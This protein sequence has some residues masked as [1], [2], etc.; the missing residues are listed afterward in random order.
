VSDE[1]DEPIE[2]AGV[3]SKRSVET[4]YWVFAGVGS[5][6]FIAIIGY[7]I[8]QCSRTNL[9]D[10]LGEIPVLGL[11]QPAEQ[12]F[13]MKPGTELLFAVSSSYSYSG[14][15]VVMLDVSLLRDGTEVGKNECNMKGFT[16]FGAS[17]SGSTTWYGDAGWTCTLHVPAEGA[18]AVRVAVRRSGKGS[19]ELS[20][21][22]VIVKLP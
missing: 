8:H 18:T 5:I 11:D 9:A 15:P 4:I 12:S 10:A 2:V 1:N 6:P 17:G 3:P 21:T 13:T 22:R 14:N 7:A 20:R 19:L 16:G